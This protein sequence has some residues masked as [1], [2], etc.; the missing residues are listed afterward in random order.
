MSRAESAPAP[1]TSAS[2][3]ATCSSTMD[4]ACRADFAKEIASNNTA[5]TAEAPAIRVMLNDECA[6]GCRI[7]P[8]PAARF[9][10]AAAASPS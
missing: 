5:A 10:P 8:A 9:N 6:M 7:A 3:H 1:A 2:C 4:A